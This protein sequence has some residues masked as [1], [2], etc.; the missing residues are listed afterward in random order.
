MA[1]TYPECDEDD[2]RSTLTTVAALDPMTVFHEPIN[3]RADNVTRIAA[4]AQSLGVELKTEVLTIRESWQNYALDSLGTVER[5]T[6]EVGLAKRPHLW[7]DK[8]L[9]SK[10]A[11]KKHSS[12][13]LQLAWLQRW[14]N[15]ISEWPVATSDRVPPSGGISRNPEI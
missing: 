7:P 14:W 5:L 10:V 1:P 2:L 3:I 11:L 13:D 9:G 12:P 4:H 6:G 15:R 8:S